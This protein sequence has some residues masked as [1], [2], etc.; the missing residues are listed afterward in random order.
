MGKIK[1]RNTAHKKML[2]KKKKNSNFI[3]SNQLTNKMKD[4]ILFNSSIYI[5]NFKKIK[6]LIFTKIFQ[7]SK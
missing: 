3:L 1:T 4:H 5:L 7:L 6:F 2:L